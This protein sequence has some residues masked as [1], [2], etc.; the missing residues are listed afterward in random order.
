MTR[1]IEVSADDLAI[2]CDTITRSHATFYSGD[3]DCEHWACRYCK[4]RVD[5]DE[6]GEDDELDIPHNPGCPALVA[7]DIRP[8]K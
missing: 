3:Y 1:I 8:R 6:I 4:G 7:R 5:T 2:V